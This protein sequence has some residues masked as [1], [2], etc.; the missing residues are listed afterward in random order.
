MHYL[1]Y[2]SLIHLLLLQC[3]LLLWPPFFI[4]VCDVFR[5]LFCLHCFSSSIN[6]ILP[7]CLL[8]IFAVWF[9]CFSDLYFALVSVTK[10]GYKLIWWWLLYSPLKPSNYHAKD[11]ILLLCIPGKKTSL[12]LSCSFPLLPFFT[13]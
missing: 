11:K 5:L 7:H 13:A 9:N 2:V 6:L 1:L 12:C 10:S 4:M 3:P 8:E